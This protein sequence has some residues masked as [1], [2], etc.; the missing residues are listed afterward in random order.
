M[1]PRSTISAGRLRP[2][3][4]A[5]RSPKTPPRKFD[6][7][8]RH[9]T[10]QPLLSL[11]TGK[12][13][14]TR[15]CSRGVA[16]PRPMKC[17]ASRRHLHPL[18]LMH[19]SKSPHLHNL[20]NQSNSSLKHLHACR[21]TGAQ[22]SPCKPPDKSSLHNS[23]CW[24]RRGSSLCTALA[25]SCRCCLLLR[26]RHNKW[27]LRHTCCNRCSRT[28]CW[29]HACRN[30]RSLKSP[31]RK[32][33]CAL[34]ATAKKRDRGLEKRTMLRERRYT[35]PRKSNAANCMLLRVPTR[36][37]PPEEV[38]RCP[39]NCLA[40]RPPAMSWGSPSGQPPFWAKSNLLR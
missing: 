7:R 12:T 30:T 32:Q 40:H 3:P 17:S 22:R 35:P 39:G 29:C 24:S 26:W 8:D 27:V 21:S 6:R 2:H 28:A 15:S 34:S 9:P 33:C 36:A 4:A 18:Q 31:P 25:P 16:R 14:D 5:G 20:D 13:P 38:P 10:S 11:T 23:R 37:P 1:P 19:C